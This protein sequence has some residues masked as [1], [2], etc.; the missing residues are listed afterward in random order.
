MPI[1]LCIVAALLVGISCPAV[2]A[3]G[4]G[5]EAQPQML[6]ASE[7]LPAAVLV[8]QYHTVV[9]E[10]LNDG[11]L[12]A[13]RIDSDFGTFEAHGDLQL[14]VRIA[15][16]E[17]LGELDRV[18]KT[19]VF[20]SALG[21][22]ATAQIEV[23]KEVAK[24]PVATVKGIPGGVGRMFRRYKWDF[25]EGVDTAK[26][27][28]G[29][30]KQ[31]ETDATETGTPSDTVEPQDA[32]NLT[33]R[34]LDAA[35]SY[36]KRYFGLNRSERYW[37]QKLGVDPYTDN[38]PLQ[39]AVRSVAQVDAS[40]GFGMKF[41]SLPRIPGINY[42]N[43]VREMVYDLDP[44]ELR[45]INALRLREMGVGEEAIASFLDNEFL[46]PSQQSAIV[47]ALSALEGV[48][49]RP[50]V[51]AQTAVSA[52][53]AVQA[54]FLTSTIAMLSLFE[55]REGGIERLI[56]DRP[57][58]TVMTTGGRLVVL[59]AVDHLAWVESLSDAFESLQRLADS[60]DVE[61]KEIWLLGSVSSRC[62][63]E[64]ENRGWIVR[65]DLPIPGA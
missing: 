24:T 25:E 57:V 47:A 34:G 13:Y 53:S 14:R 50:G 60:E 65:S 3:Q 6:V 51:V 8:G 45:R 1:R 48:P 30:D 23:V 20:L 28:L 12:N 64:L 21:R 26:E 9:D 61:A 4:L 31:E 16:I 55:D 33:A 38:E 52:A 41:V 17:A 10:V 32:E 54:S 35:G 59:A 63:S 42:L 36:S 29:N 56:S 15:E 58:P 19:E 37:Y 5:F 27:V 7:V 18:S 39:K 22:S 40:A 11:Y 44:R 2:L 49:G 62:R 43:D 46:R